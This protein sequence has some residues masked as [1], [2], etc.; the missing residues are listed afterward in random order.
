MTLER[1]TPLER[2]TPLRSKGTKAHEQPPSRNLPTSGGLKRSGRIKPMSDKRRA[3][4]PAEA[5]VRAAVFE[6]DGYRCRIKPLLKGTRWER[7]WGRLTA[8]HLKK[9]GQGG[10]Y[11]MENLISACAGHND[12]VED[13]PALAKQLGLVR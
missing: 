11:T 9:D 10:G 8:H 2:K 6:R 3:E 4:L 7:C 1:R 12:W 5:A 13:H